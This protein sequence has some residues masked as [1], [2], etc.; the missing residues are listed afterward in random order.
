MTNILR[1]HTGPIDEIAG[2]ID[3]LA[4][5]QCARACVLAH[6]CAHMCTHPMHAR[7][8]ARAHR[9]STTSEVKTTRA[10]SSMTNTSMHTLHLPPEFRKCNRILESR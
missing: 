2:T 8:C 7:T 4:S 5:A 10:L 6:T 9:W 3:K 1:Y